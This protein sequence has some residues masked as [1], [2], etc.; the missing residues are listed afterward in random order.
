VVR[1]TPQPTLLVSPAILEVPAGSSSN[2]TLTV[3]T[4]GYSTGDT[5]EF[6]IGVEIDEPGVSLQDETLSVWIGT[7]LEHWRFTHFGT[8]TNSG[9]TADS[10]DVEP[11]GLV[12]LAE[13][14]FGGD[15]DSADAWKGKLSRAEQTNDYFTVSFRRRE[16]NGSGSTETEYT[17][18]GITYTVEVSTNLVEGG[19]VT[20]TQAL[21][22]VGQPASNS[23]GTETVTVRLIPAIADGPPSRAVRVRLQ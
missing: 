8:V 1:V 23:D 13:F 16:G 2:V 19:W 10:Y 3:D 18:D 22:Q 21:E 4:T 6:I 11:D 7:P 9:T 12:N 17:I 14:A 15:P 20:G 5:D